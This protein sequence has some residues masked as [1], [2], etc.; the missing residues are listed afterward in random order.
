MLAGGIPGLQTTKMTTIPIASRKKGGPNLAKQIAAEKQG[1]CRGPN[2]LL[3]HKR[4]LSKVTKNARIERF[5]RMMMHR[6]L[7]KYLTVFSVDQFFGI[8]V[9][10]RPCGQQLI[11]IRLVFELVFNW[12]AG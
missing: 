9:L 7:H 10:H 11:L 12:P 5:T 6:K 4:S 3:P 8:L 1:K 2:R